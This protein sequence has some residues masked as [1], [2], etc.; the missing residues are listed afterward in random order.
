MSAP[1]GLLAYGA[2][3]MPLAIVELPLFVLLPNFYGDTLGLDLSTIGLVLLLTRALDAVLDPAIGHW[4]DRR[5]APGHYPRFVWAALPLLA[6]GYLALLWPWPR[7]AGALA[8]WLAA[9]SMVTYLG[10]S[11]ASIAYQAWGAAMA[12]DDAGR[13]RVTGVREGFGLLGVLLAAA[14][15]TPDGI[16][17]LSVLFIA[18]VVPAGLALLRAPD[19]VLTRGD[20]PGAGE[21]PMRGWRHVM[22]NRSFRWLLAAMVANGIATAIPATLV[23]FFVND[24]LR[25]PDRAPAFLLAYFVS[26]ALVMPLWVFL[27]ARI[28]LRHAW[29]CGMGCA[30][31]A[32]VWTLGLG[33]GDTTSFMIVCILTGAALGADLALPPA[34]LAAAI[35]DHGDGGRREGAYFG[36]WNLA[37]KFCLAAAAGMALPLLAWLGYEPGRAEADV[38]PL[39]LTYAALPCALK[40]IAAVVL[41]LE[42]LPERLRGPAAPT[43]GSAP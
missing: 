43:P 7:E 33:A 14:F 31:I 30:I 6:A 11:V 1:G 32:F 9:G 35:T 37:T 3:R 24:V 2:L 10:Y 12:A 40:L 15:L 5:S 22:A 8:A 34:L 29:L 28:G 23:L 20:R 21:G 25:A 26:G 39:S 42:P 41:V 16:P 19:P 18:L 38:L 13:A 27:A 36:I 17:V 4:I